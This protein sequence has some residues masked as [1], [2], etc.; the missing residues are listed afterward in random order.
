MASLFLTLNDDNCGIPT[1]HL[2]MDFQ[3][4]LVNIFSLKHLTKGRCALIVV[5][6]LRLDGAAGSI[7]AYAACLPLTQAVL[8][9]DLWREFFLAPRELLVYTMHVVMGSWIMEVSYHT[10]GG[11][12][13]HLETPAIMRRPYI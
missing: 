1:L 10:Y 11:D 2:S 8:K 7:V 4:D 5:Q 9:A 3:G 13:S 12:I 6:V